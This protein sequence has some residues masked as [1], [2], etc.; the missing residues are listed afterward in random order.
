MKKK[1]PL[2][3]VIM[4]VYNGSR[5]VEKAIQSI[6]DQT[7]DH[8]EYIIVDDGSTDQTWNILQ[9]FKKQFPQKIRIFRFKKNQGESFAANLAFSKSRGAYI[10]RMDADDISHPTRIA[11]QVT[12]MQAHPNIIVLGA[13]AKVI[14]QYGKTIG[15]KRS[16]IDHDTIYT[17]FGFINPMIHPSVMFRRNLLPKR[18]ILYNTN[19]TFETTDDYHTYFE[20][21]KYGTFANLPET[22]VSY[23]L[24]G[25]NK[26]LTNIKEKFWT[27]TKARLMAITRYNYQPSLLMFPAIFAQ[28]SLVLFLPEGILKEIFYHIRGLKQATLHIPKISFKISFARVMKYALFLQ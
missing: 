11:K 27:D 25:A 10:A 7:Y 21:L 22:L 12:F 5:F 23:R 26:S 15:A 6:L 20:L 2:V 24:H 13:Q 1:S 4:P 17:F 28:A 9:T 14:N 8:I 3:S 19:R 16:P 18:S